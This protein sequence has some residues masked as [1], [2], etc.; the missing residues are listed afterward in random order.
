LDQ[1]PITCQNIPILNLCDANQ[2]LVFNR[3]LVRHIKSENPEPFS[4]LS[5]HG[6]R[7]EPMRPFHISGSRA[8]GHFPDGGFSGKFP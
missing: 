4:Q 5:Q 3:P 6:I 7:N 8:I 2:G 1:L